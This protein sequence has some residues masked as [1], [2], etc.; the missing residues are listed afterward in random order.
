MPKLNTVEK[1]FWNA[2][3]EKEQLGQ[4][5]MHFHVYVCMYGMC[6]VGVIQH[7]VGLYNFR[8]IKLMKRQLC[9]KIQFALDIKKSKFK[10]EKAKA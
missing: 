7:D 4:L 3:F 6:V 2:E 9:T 8:Q 10:H 1:L 5:F